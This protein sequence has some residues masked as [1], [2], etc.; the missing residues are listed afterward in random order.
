MNHHHHC[1][2]A[3]SPAITKH[4]LGQTDSM[5]WFQISKY[6]TSMCNTYINMS[7]KTQ[8]TMNKDVLKFNGSL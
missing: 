3:M 5:L 1:A 2:C 8:Q 6:E 4:I 7:P